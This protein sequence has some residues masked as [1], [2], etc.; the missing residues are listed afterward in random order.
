LYLL[1]DRGV[2]ALDRQ[3][4]KKFPK[5]ENRSKKM[6]FFK[7]E[8]TFKEFTKAEAKNQTEKGSLIRRWEQ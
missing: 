1:V 7:A 4:G 2:D 3:G 5:K 8:R 6:A